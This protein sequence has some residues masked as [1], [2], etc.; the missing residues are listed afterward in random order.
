V[1]V[2]L[3]TPLWKNYLFIT[4]DTAHDGI[5]WEFQVEEINLSIPQEILAESW[6]SRVN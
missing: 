1:I 2:A 4:M 5:D 6:Q 3:A